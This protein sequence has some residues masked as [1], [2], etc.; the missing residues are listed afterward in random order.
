PARPPRRACR[1]CAIDPARSR[2]S[3]PPVPRK[4]GTSVSTGPRAAPRPRPRRSTVASLSPRQNDRRW[5]L[6]SCRRTTA[7]PPAARRKVRPPRRSRPCALCSESVAHAELQPPARIDQAA[8]PAEIRIGCRQRRQESL[9]AGEVVVAEDVESLEHHRRLMR[10]MESKRLLHVQIDAAIGP[11][12]RNDEREMLRLP[13]VALEAPLVDAAP[14]RLIVN[15]IRSPRAERDEGADDEAGGKSYHPRPHERMP[16]LAVSR[17]SRIVGHAR[18]IEAEQIAARL[19]RFAERVG[20]AVAV[21]RSAHAVRPID[22]KI[23]TIEPRLSPLWIRNQD[24][25]KSGHGETARA[26]RPPRAENEC[27][28]VP[29]AHA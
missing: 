8:R 27:Q 3:D 24:V 29:A 23:Q 22:L 19:F 16:L 14:A 15:G 26:V 4:T 17:V 21:L 13:R 28:Q 12:V 7:L 11:R 10:A 1:R 25:G 20:K 18:E 6:A 2:L 9:V 5:G